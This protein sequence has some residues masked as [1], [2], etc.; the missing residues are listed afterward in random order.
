MCLFSLLIRHIVSFFFSFHANTVKISLFKC[1]SQILVL[2]GITT[3]GSSRN[4]MVLSFF[5]YPLRHRQSYSSLT[6]PLTQT[7]VVVPQSLHNYAITLMLQKRSLPL[8]R[9]KIRNMTF[10]FHFE[11]LRE[12]T[13][14]NGREKQRENKR[15]AWLVQTI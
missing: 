5:S 8:R 9:R 13:R 15:R 3:S 6:S 7:S 11:D 1:W 4:G 10:F 14:K 12:R 2:H